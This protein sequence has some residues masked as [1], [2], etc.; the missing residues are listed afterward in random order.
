T[1]GKQTHW[2]WYVF[3][4]L[5]GL[6]HSAAARRYG[7][8]GRAE[9]QAYLEDSVLRARL[10]E[11]TRA[12]SERLATGSPLLELMGSTIDAQKLVSSLTLFEQVSRELASAGSGPEFSALSAV[13]Q[14]VLAAAAAQGYPRC[15]FTT[16]TLG[17]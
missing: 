12:L 13:A 5:A 11:I 2:I 15:S 9:A 10:L 17:A 8:A 16:Q 3:P 14:R 7:L 4:Q 6:G 1:T